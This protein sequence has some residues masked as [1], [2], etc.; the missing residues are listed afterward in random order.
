MKTLKLKALACFLMVAMIFAACEQDQIIPNNDISTVA[1][2]SELG[3]PQGVPSEGMGETP[4]NSCGSLQTEESRLHSLQIT[5]LVS[6][7]S[8]IINNRS[9]TTFP[10][11]FHILRN[12]N[13]SG[14]TT[15]AVVNQRLNDLNQAFSGTNVQFEKCG[16]VIFHDNNQWYVPLGTNDP[17]TF[18]YYNNVADVINLYVVLNMSFDNCC[19]G[20]V[21]GLATYP[22]NNLA[23]TDYIALGLDAFEN[24]PDVVAHEFGH[25]FDLYHTQESAFFGYEDVNNCSNTGDLCCDTP[26]DPGLIQYAATPGC[27]ACDWDNVSLVNSNCQYVGNQSFSG[28]GVYHNCAV[29]YTPTNYSAWFPGNP[30]INPLTNNFMSYSPVDGCRDSFTPNQ[31]T[32]INAAASFPDRAGLQCASSGGSTCPTPA[33]SDLTFGTPSTQIYVY[34]YPYQGITHQIRFRFGNSGIWAIQDPTTSHYSTITN[35]QQ[36]CATYEV[37]IRQQC[38]GTWSDWSAS[39]TFT[40]KPAKPLSS[41]LTNPTVG[42]NYVHAY[43]NNHAGDQKQFQLRKK[44]GTFIKNKF[45]MTHYRTFTG[46]TP[47]TQYK[48]RVRKRC[49]TSGSW[50]GWTGYKH[51]TT[52]N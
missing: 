42:C 20:C 46:L 2:G 44:D 31:I 47:N 3:K 30:T 11:Q 23:T 39:A 13:G 48:Y 19:I 8:S 5:E 10:V 29:S 22:D 49:G 25:F 14:G 9:V 21:E 43:C 45:T 4:P 15:E 37:Q 1:L 17:H 40:T 36:D 32:R 35:L 51:F 28:T 38:S 26:P 41:D 33:A 34:A 27:G 50:S 6:S 12:S 18:A 52:C 16:D 24:K 7:N